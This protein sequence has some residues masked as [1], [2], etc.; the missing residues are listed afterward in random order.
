M[1]ANTSLKLDRSH[2]SLTL[3]SLPRCNGSEVLGEESVVVPQRRHVA[4][5]ETAAHFMRDQFVAQPE[6]VGIRRK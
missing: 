3:H 1:T 2:A 5:S 4:D 6:L